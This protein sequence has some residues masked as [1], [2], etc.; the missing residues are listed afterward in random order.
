[1]RPVQQMS[2]H[3]AGA[4]ATDDCNLHAVILRFLAFVYGLRDGLRPRL[5]KIT[6]AP[7]VFNP[8]AAESP[9]GRVRPEPSQ[10]RAFGN[11]DFQ[12]PISEHLTSTWKGGM[13]EL[14]L[15]EL[16]DSF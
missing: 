16:P 2:G 1:M 3:E 4:A 14:G 7:Q 9:A 8:R 11:A 10:V 13:T 5:L 15:L 6:T 12:C